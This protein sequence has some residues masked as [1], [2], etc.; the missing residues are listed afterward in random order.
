MSFWTVIQTETRRE[1]VAA[2]H[3]KRAG[4][5]I[6]VPS[7]QCRSQGIDKIVPLFPSYLFTRVELTNWSPIRWTIAVVRVLMNGEIPA[8]LPES[9]MIDIRKREGP[10]GLI[11]LPRRSWIKGQTRLMVIRG[12]FRGLNAIYQD[13]SPRER[14]QVLLSMLGREVSVELPLRDVETLDVMMRI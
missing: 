2:E 7:L 9:A 12:S 4:Y 1:F 6:Y 13:S 8:Q 3:L 10:D 11:K 14:V 5:E